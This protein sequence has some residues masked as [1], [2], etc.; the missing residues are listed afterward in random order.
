MPRGEAVLWIFAPD[1]AGTAPIAAAVRRGTVAVDVEPLTVRIDEWSPE[2]MAWGDRRT[3]SP[4]FGDLGGFDVVN[5]AS[6][7]IRGLLI[8]P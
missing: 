5:P 8:W 4:G 2:T 6:D 7:I 1:A 3:A